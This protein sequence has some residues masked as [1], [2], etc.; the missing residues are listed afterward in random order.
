MCKVCVF[1]IVRLRYIWTQNQTQF[2]EVYKFK[3]LKVLILNVN[4]CYSNLL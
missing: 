2:D 3:I 4:V 1:Y